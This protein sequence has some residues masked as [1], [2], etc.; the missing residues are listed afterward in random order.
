MSDQKDKKSLSATIKTILHNYYFIRVVSAFFTIFLIATITFVMMHAI[1]GGPFS[2]ERAL[3]EEIIAA[4]NAKYHL[5]DPLWKQ[6]LDYMVGL[7]TFD[8]GPSF[9][10][11]GFEVEELIAAGFPISAKIGLMAILLIILIGIPVGIVSAL[12]QNRPA[13]Y[14]VMFFAT[15]GV[16][17]PSF[18]VAALFIYIFAGL[19]NW[20]D[21]FGLNRPSSYI[22]PVVAL[23]GYSLAFVSRLTRSSMLEVMRQ[24][25]IR[26]ARANGLS[27]FKVIY[28]HALKNALIPVVTYIGP[29]I[30]AILTGSFVIEKVFTIP[31]IGKYFVQSVSDRDYTMILGTTVFYAVLYVVMVLLVDVA[32]SL[33]DPRIRL[34]KK[35][36]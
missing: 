2:R 23:V 19:L 17:I 9:K 1:P 18:V 4:L 33:I 5:D 3:P 21:A 16:T 15:L 6:Y 24:D 36:E 32:Y 26:T 31:G 14:L 25:Y 29:M 10:R 7:I 20:V 11:T 27:R 28:K 30:A 34:G 22:G 13:D 35:S 12:R 8:L